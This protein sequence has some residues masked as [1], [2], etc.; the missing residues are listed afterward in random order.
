MNFLGH[1]FFSDLTPEAL[2]G[3]LWPDFARR[4]SDQP[5]SPA[6]FNHFDRHQQI[7]QLTDHHL[8]L[9]PVRKAL[10]PTF[11]KTT[12][13]VIDMMLDHHL[14]MHWPNYHPLTLEQ[15]AKA[16]YDNLSAFDAL[17]HPKRMA[18]T[19]HWMQTHN[20]FVSYREADGLDQAL[21]GMARRLK[22][23]NPMRQYRQQAIDATHTYADQLSE[24]VLWL[25][26]EL[27]TPDHRSD[28]AG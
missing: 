6:F 27:P 3:S 18:Q 10:R 24:F 21:N 2:S 16:C 13:V 19:L 7:D 23:D 9:E 15:F 20:W 14:A 28:S 1:C 17:P 5:V 8:L 25:Q 11:R 4:P 12:P 26:S 22:F